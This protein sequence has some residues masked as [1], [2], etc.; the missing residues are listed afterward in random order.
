MT[1]GRWYLRWLAVWA[2]GVPAIHGVM[3]AILG[4][5]VLWAALVGGW[6]GGVLCGLLLLGLISILSGRPFESEDRA[7]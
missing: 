2:V 3:S 1:P 6:L 5:P 4:R 7:K